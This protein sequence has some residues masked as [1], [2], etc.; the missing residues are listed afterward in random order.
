MIREA[1]LY[2]LERQGLRRYEHNPLFYLL[3]DE[4]DNAFRERDVDVDYVLENYY[5]DKR[6]PRNVT[7]G[8][9]FERFSKRLKIVTSSVS[10]ATEFSNTQGLVYLVIGKKGIGKTILL[11]YYSKKVLD[12]I[13]NNKRSKTVAIYLDLKNKKSD[14]NFLNR[15][16]GSLMEELFE[17]VY[18]KSKM[19]KYLFEP[20]CIRKLHRRYEIISEDNRL[21]ERMLDKKEESIDC[22]FRFLKSEGYT[23]VVIIDNID[24]FGVPYVVSIIDK[25][26]EMKDKYN[27]KCI[28][29]VRD[30]W[31]PAQLEIDDSELCSIHLSEPDVKEIIKKRLNAIDTDSASKELH[32][33][34]DDD[35]PIVL[36][37]SDIIDSFH[38]IVEDLMGTPS[39]ILNKLFKLTNYD[40]REFLRNLYYFF[41]S[42]Y[43]YS[44]PN[45]NKAL[46]DKIRETDKNLSIPRPRQTHFFD[47]LEGFMT[48]HALCYDIHESK[49]FNIFFHKFE[50]PEGFNY[51]NTLIFVRI[52]QIV[53]ETCNYISKED[54]I[55]QLKSIGYY[56]EK[57][58][59]NAI[60]KLLKESLLESPDGKGYKDV[61][62][63]QM[64]EKGE[65][66][67]N[68]LVLELKY[69]LYV[70]DEV[71]MPS[72]YRVDVYKKF[73][74]EEIPLQMGNLS[75]KLESV[76]K[77]INF[78]EREEDEE[79]KMC[80]DGFRSV[81]GRLKNET[82]LSTVAGKSIEIA[83]KK[84]TLFG[85]KGVK[86]LRSISVFDNQPNE[87]ARV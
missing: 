71:P 46:L 49:I 65:I 36:T 16:P 52:L 31:T 9:I 12:T 48:P 10:L 73:G 82:N 3:T 44:R 11:N 13:E 70:C 18:Y 87:E 38:R 39:E 81:L 47:Y 75:L 58:I 86:K 14:A 24:D 62:K 34:Y 40:V 76:I 26:R 64:S 20:K 59:V 17:N 45:F 6:G 80:Q 68:T 8:A 84:M 1:N 83:I 78:L 22:L 54:V 67:L 51:M 7:N 55:S 4:F 63:L 77:F 25:C 23:V 66:Y 50:Y 41:H 85:P 33:V 57:A 37:S 29:A 53:P 19:K 35:K 79:K 61:Q 28:V 74:D 5:I 27:A 30:Y 56:D 2:N 69:L 43:L 32:F 21:V 42:P 72:E 15:L 60:S